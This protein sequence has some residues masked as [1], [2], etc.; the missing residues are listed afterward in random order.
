MSG[1]DLQIIHI[2]WAGPERWLSA[3]GKQW[4]FEDSYYC[5]P[6]VLCNKTREP[7]KNEPPESHSI[8]SHINVWY[9]QGKRVREVAGKVWC[10]YSTPLE[11][12]LHETPNVR[13]NAGR[14]AGA[15]A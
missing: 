5:G 6:I 8:W 3:G 7:A 11:Q 4:V 12:A 14:T 9:Q 15:G 10:V 1:D 13:G 2:S